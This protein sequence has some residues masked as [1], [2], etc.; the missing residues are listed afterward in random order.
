M[1]HAITGEDISRS[2]EMV[3]Q[4]NP[5]QR[6]YY[7]DNLRA[8]AML[9]GV[10]FHAALAYSP[11]MHNLWFTTSS[12][13]SWL[14]DFF[15]FFTHLF[16]MPVFFLISGFFAIMLIEKR[17]VSGLLKNRAVRIVLPFVI[18]FP[19]LLIAYMVS[20]G[21]A[22]ENVKNLSPMLQFIKMMQAN[23]NAPQPPLTTMHLWF[24]YNLFMFVL[25]LAIAHKANLLNR[26]WVTQLVSPKFVIFVFP[27]LLVPALANQFAPHPAPEKFY[28]E[29]W[30][31]GFYG[32][33][34]LVGA[35]I[36]NKQSI[37]VEFERYKHWL[38]L[39]SLVLYGYFFYTLPTTITPEQT[40]QMM[41]GFKFDMS[42]LPVAI[43]EAYV[44]VYM[45]IYLLIIAKKFLN[46]HSAT[47]KLIADSS[48]WIYL[49]HMPVLLM[50]QFVLADVDL[51]IWIE[52]L[53]SSLLT[54]LICFV[55]YLI[56][57]RWTPIGWMLNGKK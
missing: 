35:L 51:G 31:F 25:V 37:L 15:A 14:F 19:V 30:S 3:Q 5:S 12:E 13:S 44:A 38:L 26:Q 27:L 8:L 1:N 7:M 39:V 43:A 47:I 20:I 45:S 34:F 9:L 48:Y 29:L 22:V 6:L 23:P 28:P 21:W 24:L 54:F 17:G 40:M 10:L 32:L 4:T 46:Q 52:F 2:E 56:I 55:S 11:L 57:V 16:R 36:Y 50:V 49:V 33:F 53:V 42:H 41:A 18:F